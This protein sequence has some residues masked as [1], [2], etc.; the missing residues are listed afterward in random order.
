VTGAANQPRPGDG[1]AV[2]IGEP[3]PKNDSFIDFLLP[4]IPVRALHQVIRRRGELTTQRR[5]LKC[6]TDAG[7]QDAGLVSQRLERRSELKWLVRSEIGNLLNSL[8]ELVRQDRQELLD[9]LKLLLLLM[10]QLLQAVYLLRQTLKQLKDL[11]RD[12]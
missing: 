1:A 6:A 4:V 10:R 3:D 11:L 5:R 9:L 12:R 2:Q 7:R 8:L